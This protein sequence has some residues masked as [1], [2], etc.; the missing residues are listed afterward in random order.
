M[1]E[2]GVAT[3][4]PSGEGWTPGGQTCGGYMIHFLAPE[5]TAFQAEVLLGSTWKV[6]PER[7]GPMINHLEFRVKD[8]LM[9]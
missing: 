1:S 5:T 9:A 6:E 3:S 7:R 4:A 8:S 2:S